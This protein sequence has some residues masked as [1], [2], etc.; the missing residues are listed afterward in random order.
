[1]VQKWTAKTELLTGPEV[2]WGY[3]DG[4]NGDVISLTFFF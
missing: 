2:I 4:Q 3:T 1:M